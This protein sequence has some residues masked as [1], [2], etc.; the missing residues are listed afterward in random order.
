[1]SRGGAR[2]GAGKPKGS[3]HKTTIEREIAL[4]QLR[5]G[6]MMELKPVMR[7][8][9]DSARG[10]TV[11]Y[12][13]KKVK[14]K[15]SGKYERTGE[16]TKVTNQ[17]RVEELLRGDCS[18]DDWYYITTKDPNIA[19]IKELWDRAFG[20]PKESIEHSGGIK[21]SES[22]DKEKIEKAF[23]VLL[24]LDGSDTTT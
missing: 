10:L 5:Q 21:L 18:G 14:N 2:P 11:M 24:K 12:Q 1:M 8:A 4:E 9:L 17:S 19:S 20:K 6:V 22:E 15:S 7:A 16:L 23:N 13:K 3:K